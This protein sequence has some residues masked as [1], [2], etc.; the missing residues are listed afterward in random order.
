MPPAAPLQSRLASLLRKG[1]VCHPILTMT[2]FWVLTGT[3]VL[4]AVGLTTLLIV[5]PLNFLSGWL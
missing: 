2:A 1:L 3:G 5:F 4:L